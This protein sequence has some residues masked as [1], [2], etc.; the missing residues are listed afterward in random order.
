MRWLRFYIIATDKKRRVRLTPPFNNI[1]LDVNILHKHKKVKANFTLLSDE[2]KESILI[3]FIAPLI[4]LLERIY[5]EVLSGAVR[6]PTGSA[7]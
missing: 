1:F 6:K 2:K 4:C 5:L 7:Q 3:K